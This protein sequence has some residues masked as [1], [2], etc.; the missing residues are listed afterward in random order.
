MTLQV[1]LIADCRFD[2]PLIS[3]PEVSN[4]EKTTQ[5]RKTERSNLICGPKL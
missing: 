4:R 2:N 5:R 1:Y 3:G